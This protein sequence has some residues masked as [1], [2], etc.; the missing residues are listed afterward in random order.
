MK[1]YPLFNKLPLM[2]LLSLGLAGSPLIA[3]ADDDHDRHNH[4]QQDHGKPHHRAYHHKD[5]RD[6][7]N[8]R[9]HDKR[10]GYSKHKKSH[11]VKSPDTYHWRN[12][13]VRPYLV[14]HH[15]NIVVARPYGQWCL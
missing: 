4:H 12:D 11:P 15:R 3:S 10:G 6:H 1:L 5:H 8:N 2:A 13:K 9:H 7:K 14:R